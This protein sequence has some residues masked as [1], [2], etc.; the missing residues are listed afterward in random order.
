M[1]Y[2][3][4]GL[5][6]SLSFPYV[7]TNILI[8]ACAIIALSLIFFDPKSYS[9]A[10]MSSLLVLLFFIEVIGLVHTYDLRNGFLHLER[11]SVFVLLPIIFSI[12]ELSTEFNKKKIWDFYLLGSLVVILFS[13]LTAIYKVVSGEKAGI[14]GVNEFFTL[15][16]ASAVGMSHVQF[17]LNISIALLYSVYQVFCVQSQNTIYRSLYVFSFVVFSIILMLVMA[18][19]AII[20]TF[21]AVAFILIATKGINKSKLLLVSSVLVVLFVVSIRLFPPLK[22]RWEQ[23]LSPK[24]TVIVN[25]KRNYYSTRTTTFSCAFKI[26]QENYLFGVGTGDATKFLNDC[27]VQIGMNDFLDYDSHCQY[28]DYI[29]RLGVL[30]VILLLLVFMAPLLNSTFLNKDFL[31]V[32]VLGILILCLITENMFDVA[33]GVLSYSF[34]YCFSSSYNSLN[35]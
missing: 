6:F 20:A 19:T 25:D 22:S 28:L 3:V 21:A 33:K 29:I 17:G 24:E 30:G 35:S 27:Y 9:F 1:L 2:A 8:V 14:W 26:A 32:G 34:F 12:S 7:F 5:S 16:L 11:K 18:K 4:C 31:Q 10:R 13:F 15:K 23:I